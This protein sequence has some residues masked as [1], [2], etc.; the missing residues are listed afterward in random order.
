MSEEFGNYT[1]DSYIRKIDFNQFI[2]LMKEF[3]FQI[4]VCNNS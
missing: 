2:I 4:F 3:K 1:I